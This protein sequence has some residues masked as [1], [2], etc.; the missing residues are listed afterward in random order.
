MQIKSVCCHSPNQ[1]HIIP[2]LPDHFIHIHMSSFY[3]QPCL[4]YPIL[5][6]VLEIN[7]PLRSCQFSWHRTFFYSRCPYA[8]RISFNKEGP[9]LEFKRTFNCS[10]YSAANKLHNLGNPCLLT[11]S[12]NYLQN[13]EHVQDLLQG[14]LWCVIIPILRIYHLYEE[15]SNCILRVSSWN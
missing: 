8:L 1:S 15:S 12:H 10:P 11:G 4:V 14:A 13:E 9:G 6:S 2:T 7:I 3:I 5:P